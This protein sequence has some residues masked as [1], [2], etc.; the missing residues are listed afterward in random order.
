MYADLDYDSIQATMESAARRCGCNVVRLEIPEPVTHD[1]LVAFYRDALARH[2]RTRLLL[3][4]HVSHRTGLVMPVKAIAAEARARSVTVVVDAAHSWGQLDFR[5]DDLDVDFAGFNLHKWMG[6]PI[7]VGVMY[8]RKVRLEDIAPNIS[9]W[10]DEADRVAGRVHTGTSNLAACL[11]VPN[12]FTF[13]DRIGASAKEARLRYLRNRWTAPLRGVAGVDILTP[14]DPRL[15]AGITSFRLAG[16]TSAA[17]NHAIA[18]RLLNDH[19]IFTVHRDG[20]ARGACVRV[21]PAVFNSSADMDG[22]AGAI[23]VLVASASKD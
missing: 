8:I 6:A 1:A 17:D 2:R 5:I 14:D 10:P 9:A 19:G 16:K 22:L 18:E 15:H 23:R 12:A 13:H 11:T 7:G 4:T 21:T 20:V 3:L